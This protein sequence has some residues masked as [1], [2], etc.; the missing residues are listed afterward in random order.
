MEGVKTG[1]VFGRLLQETGWKPF[2]DKVMVGIWGALRQRAEVDVEGYTVRTM[3]KHKRTGGCVFGISIRKDGRLLV[4]ST[5]TEI[6]GEP[7]DP[8]VLMEVFRH[9]EECVLTIGKRSL[10]VVGESNRAIRRYQLQQLRGLLEVAMDVVE[11]EAIC[12]RG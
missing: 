6:P 11:K 12:G 5:S 10:L 3:V 7:A 8:L 2:G 1:A 4:F 9:A